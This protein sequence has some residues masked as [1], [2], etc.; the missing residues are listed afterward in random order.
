MSKT[1]QR[2]QKKLAKKRSKEIAKRRELARQRNAMQS[3]A[4]Q[5]SAAANGSIRHC[6][7]SDHLFDDTSK[8]GAVLISRQL[9]DGRIACV[10]FLVDA[11]CLGVKDHY[12]VVAFPSQINDYVDQN[13]ERQLMR[14]SSPAFAR[15]LVES[16]IDYARQ[17]ELPPA[18]GYQKLAAIWG[19]IDPNECSDEF[20]FGAPNGKP[21][22][23]NGP[24][25][26][27]DFQTRVLESLERTAGEGNF[28]FVFMGGPG[29]QF[30]DEIELLDDDDGAVEQAS[31][32]NVV[33]LDD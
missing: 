1:E 28:E 16:A 20:Q 25:D 18:S 29:L 23:I 27:A 30:P 12:A 8:I 26:S 24:Y 9:P 31:S 2:R 33:Y 5:I 10:T 22:Y 21:R 4:G 15:K 17:F 13:T 11:M 6:L 3:I 7:V 32:A 14:S 19:D